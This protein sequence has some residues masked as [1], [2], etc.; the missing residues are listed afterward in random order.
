[1]HTY[2]QSPS[3]SSKF[4]LSW[5][6]LLTNKS[7]SKTLY[8]NS[9]DSQT[10]TPTKRRATSSSFSAACVFCTTKSTAT[11]T[12]SS[13]RASGTCTGRRPSSICVEL[14]SGSAGTFSSN[15]CR[16]WR[17]RSRRVLNRRTWLPGKPTTSP[18][19]YSCRKP[20]RPH[21]HSSTCGS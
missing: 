7:H 21:L 1:M 12:R 16:T 18:K 13:S 9:L 5:P 2:N 11:S 8:S 4:E 10:T 20:F 14:W 19:F 3:G 17:A 15:A 6:H